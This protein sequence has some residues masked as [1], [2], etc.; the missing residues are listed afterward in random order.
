[1][2]IHILTDFKFGEYY[3]TSGPLVFKKYLFWEL[4][5]HA[6]PHDSIRSPPDVYIEHAS[7]LD[8]K[9]SYWD[10]PS[11][12][13]S[14]DS[15]EAKMVDR[16]YKTLCAICGPEVIG[17]ARCGNPISAEIEQ[18]VYLAQHVLD[19]MGIRFWS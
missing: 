14:D 4:I 13:L 9:K 3:L 17:H 10:E 19:I 8:K 18:K 12:F 16:R 1:M 11:W 7:T 6:E 2:R 5:E 15:T